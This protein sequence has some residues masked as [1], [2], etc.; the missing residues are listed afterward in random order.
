[1]QYDESLYAILDRYRQDPSFPFNDW[2]TSH[3]SFFCL[4]NLWDEIFQLAHDVS[5]DTYTAVQDVTQDENSSVYFVRNADETKKIRIWHGLTEEGEPDVAFFWGRYP[6]LDKPD[7][8]GQG[9][10]ATL[11]GVY[12][13]EI[14]CDFD[15]TR[16]LAAAVMLYDFI[17]TDL[18]THAKQIALEESFEERFRRYFPLPE[19]DFSDDDASEDED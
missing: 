14:S 13:L 6:D 19:M 15:R 12:M 4:I 2:V 7:A 5:E 18:S 8:G 10:S 3:H 9:Y 16:L 17:H 11:E 1:M